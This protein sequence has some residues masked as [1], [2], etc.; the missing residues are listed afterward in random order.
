MDEQY[1]DIADLKRPA[2]G[3]YPPDPEFFRRFC[4]IME[5]KMPQYKALVPMRLIRPFDPAYHHGNAGAIQR[6]AQGTIGSLVLWVYQSGHMFVMSDD[7]GA[8]EALRLAQVEFAPCLVMGPELGQEVSHVHK[9]TPKQVMK[10]MGM[11]K[12]GKLRV[13]MV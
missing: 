5:G 2:E 11:E 6:M 12:P 10:A 4:L 1:I 7:H 13:R 9:L 8:W 3:S